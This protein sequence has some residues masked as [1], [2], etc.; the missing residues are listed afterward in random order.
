MNDSRDHVPAYRTIRVTA[1]EAPAAAAADTE[2]WRARGTYP[3]L[4]FA[5]PVFG[6]AREREEGGW[7]VQPHFPGLALQDARDSM[8]S[9]FRR[10]AQEA[11]Q[12]GDPA[13][14]EECMRAAERMD[15][16]PVDELTVLG[17]RHRV[18]RAERFIR[19]GSAGP[20]P[21]RPTDADPAEPGQAHDVPD[22]TA[23]FVIDPVTA[24]GMSEGVLK[25][26]LLSSVYKDGTVPADAR[27]DSARA[28]QTHPG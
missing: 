2:A 6:V 4:R 15:W 22:P 17:T 16:E 10:L 27:D 9:M 3:D 18:V 8:G 7:E 25:V 19:S 28:A 11:E 13:G 26:E 14:Y 23:G 12:S 1:P 5:G 20:E 24:T 21:P